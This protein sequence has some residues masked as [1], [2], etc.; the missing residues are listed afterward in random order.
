M[1][2]IDKKV[3]FMSKAAQNSIKQ[4]GML[5]FAETSPPGYSPAAKTFRKWRRVEEEE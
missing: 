3:K 5:S 1:G 4:H 2:G